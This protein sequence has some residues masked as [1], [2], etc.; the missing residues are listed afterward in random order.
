MEEKDRMKDTLNNSKMSI[1]EGNKNVVCG[2]FESQVPGFVT[3][4]Q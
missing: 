2:R 3:S 4:V 1:M